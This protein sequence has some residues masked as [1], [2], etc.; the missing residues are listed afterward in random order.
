M[1]DIKQ[2]IESVREAVEPKLGGSIRILG[3]G[4]A[5]ERDFLDCAA[6]KPVWESSA[7]YGNAR[8]D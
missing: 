2:S 6:E 7:S 8:S 5:L 4:F 3:T 1:K